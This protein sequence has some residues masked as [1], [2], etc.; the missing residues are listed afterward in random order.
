[1]QPVPGFVPEPAA[2]RQNPAGLTPAGASVVPCAG[3]RSLAF[4]LPAIGAGGS[5]HVVTM[6]CNHFSR[7]GSAVR[8]ICFEPSGATP[9]YPLDP[10][11]TLVCL[12][13]P[14]R[15]RGGIASLWTMGRRYGLL[16]AEL[17]RQRPDAV[18]AFL[19]RTAVLAA[20]AAQS[21]GIPVLVSERNNPVRQPVGRVW[22][23]LRRR[24]YGRATAL[25]TMTSGAGQYFTPAA[26]RTDRVIPNHANLPA[27][28][29]P[30]NPAGRRLVAV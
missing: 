27:R 23:W 3:P 24:A 13:H 18:I 9:F 2:Y 26:G 19:T 16:R 6:L 10:A 29:T 5:E 17:S 7:Q 28:P 15:R 21:L 4:V 1:M 30:F 11:V 20:L 8:L 22:E 14:S 25:V 12:G